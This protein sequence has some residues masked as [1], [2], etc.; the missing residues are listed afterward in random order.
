MTTPVQRA[1][2]QRQLD[3]AAHRA[4]TLEHALV[5]LAVLILAAAARE[6]HPGA[7]RISLSASEEGDWLWIDDVDEDLN[8]P[9]LT[10]F[11]DQYANVACHLSRNAL[12]ASP[13]LHENG[14]RDDYQSGRWY[15]DITAALT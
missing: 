2:W 6:T 5:R 7:K 9:A 13:F 3:D 15:I 4:K 1:L 14:A 12:D 11:Q 10:A 8:D